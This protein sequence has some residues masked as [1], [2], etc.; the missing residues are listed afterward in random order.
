MASEVWVA[1]G[2]NSGGAGVLGVFA[3]RKAAEAGTLSDG[4][5]L[6]YD[7][8]AKATW[9]RKDKNHNVTI[10]LMPVQAEMWPA[11]AEE[12]EGVLIP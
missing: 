4:M 1:V 11:A 2:H 8:Q 6:V 3:S 12:V 10:E 9:S 5:D 7:G